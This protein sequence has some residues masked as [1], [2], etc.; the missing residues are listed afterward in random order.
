MELPP[1][2]K[3]KSS[4]DMF[5][6]NKTEPFCFKFMSTILNI[7]F[8]Q[9]FSQL[10]ARQN[11]SRP[12]GEIFRIWTQGNNVFSRL[13]GKATGKL[14]S[15]EQSLSNIFNGSLILLFLSFTHLFHCFL[16]FSQL[17]LF[18]FLLNLFRNKLLR[19]ITF[20]NCLLKK[21]AFLPSKTFVFK[22]ACLF[23]TSANW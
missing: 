15:Y 1:N 21:G 7:G 16:Y 14:F 4:P 17:S 19:Y 3:W 20:L 22:E 5:K 8:S 18:G 11:K 6:Y 2:I 13:S 9:K 10:T 12:G 23:T